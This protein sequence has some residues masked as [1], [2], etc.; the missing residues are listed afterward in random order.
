[1]HI[2]DL[3][4]QQLDEAASICFAQLAKIAIETDF[5][6]H[7]TAALYAERHPRSVFLDDVRQATKAAVAAG[8]TTDVTWAAPLVPRRVVA[9]FLAY[10]RPRSVVDQL[11]ALGVR[12]VPFYSGYPVQ[13]G[14]GV[15]SWIGQGFA[16]PVT[17]FDF[18]NV[19]VD[20]HKASGIIVLTK[21][22]VRSTDP[23][24][25]QLIRDQLA[26]GVIEFVDRQFL[27][28]SIAEV[29]G[30]NPASVTNGA[31][32][33][34]SAGATE[35]NARTD[36][37]ALISAFYA[38]NAD[39][40]R[41]VLIMSP[42]TATALAIALN[43][44]TLGQQGGTVYG[45]PVITSSAVGN[46]IVAMDAEQVLMADAPVLELDTATSA[47]VQMDSVPDNPTASTTVLVSLWQRGLIGLRVER[48]I[49]WKRATTNS[50]RVLTGVAY[51]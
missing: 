9:G 47:S 51:T 28:P 44:P 35:A 48:W 43:T 26:K 45:V 32:T 41:A 1:M 17:K 2:A 20:S 24:T 14:G 40:A 50:V 37:K 34:A 25:D 31:P 3:T 42:A 4:R 49:S 18:S 30:V 16:K 11:L 7:Q 33:A 13:T 8:T 29:A 22:L 5:A 12:R 38:A 36:I 19:T 46:R 27:D 23:A 21:E 10:L 15:F 6:P 39:A